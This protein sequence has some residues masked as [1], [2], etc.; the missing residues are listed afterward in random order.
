MPATLG[1]FVICPVLTSLALYGQC[2]VPIVMLGA[3][4]GSSLRRCSRAALFSAAAAL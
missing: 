4:L 3:A 1:G 2:L